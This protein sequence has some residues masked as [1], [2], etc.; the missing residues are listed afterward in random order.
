[1]LAEIE[2][3]RQER[4]MTPYAFMGALGRALPPDAAVVE[5]AVTTHQYLLERLGVLEDPSGYI[6]HRGWALGWGLGCAVGVKLAWPDRPAVALS[7]DGAAMYGIQALWTAAH[8]RIP[9]VFIIANNAQYKI[10]KVSGDVMQLPQMVQRNYLA[11]DLVDPEI[12]F[13]GLA[14]SLG[15]QAQRVTGPEEL[16]DRVRDAVAGTEPVLLDVIVDR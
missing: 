8:H 9:V 5:E 11:M 15:V 10:L 7:G 3:Q 2:T 1:L 13:V 12:D 14:R 16:S 6:A 4:P